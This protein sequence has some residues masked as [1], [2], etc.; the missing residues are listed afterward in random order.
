M[1]TTYTQLYFCN[2]KKKP[3]I[4]ETS[5]FSLDVHEISLFVSKKKPL[6]LENCNYNYVFI[7][8]FRKLVVK[9]K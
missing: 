3:L 9:G 2:F 1:E 5:C 8:I 7:T 4:Y 6:K